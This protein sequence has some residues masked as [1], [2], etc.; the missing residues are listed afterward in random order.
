[1]NTTPEVMAANA[2]AFTPTSVSARSSWQKKALV[3]ASVVLGTAGLAVAGSA[4]WVKHNVYASA[5]QPVMLSASEQTELDGKLRTLETGASAA[6]AQAPVDPEVVKRTL[7]ISDREINAFLAQQGLGEQ[8]KVSLTKG[9]A[10]ATVLVPM[11][12]DVPFVG[13]TT[14][15]LQVAIGAQMDNSKQFA[16]RV[17]DVSVGGVPLPNAWLG[18]MKGANLLAES[19]ISSDPAVKGFLAGIRD[20]EIQDGNLR[21]ILNE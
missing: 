14:L 3:I 10:A 12:K 17:T 8:V 18:N 6:P 15:R 1:M 21:V 9:G 5:M 13:G 19:N 2:A 20:F 16:L 4:W 11:D 7:T